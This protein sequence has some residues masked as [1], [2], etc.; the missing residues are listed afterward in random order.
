MYSRKKTV[1]LV[2]AI[3]ES[4]KNGIGGVRYACRSLLDS[5]LS[6]EM[7]WI[8]L[9]STV[10]IGSSLS[11][12]ALL[13]F[14]R[15]LRILHSLVVYPDIDSVLIFGNYDFT[16]F[17]EKGFLIILSK[18]FEKRT[19]LS[20]R[21]EIRKCKYDWL[22]TPFRNWVFRNCDQV[23]C[24]SS[25]AAKSLT[26]L[27]SCTTTK[28]TVIMNWINAISYLPPKK[29]VT[30]D[31]ATI[32]EFTFIF[33]GHLTM[34]KAPDVL[35]SAARILKERGLS[36][37]VVICGHGPLFDEL[38]QDIVKYQLSTAVQLCG[39]VIGEALLDMLWNADVF[40]LPSHSEGMPNA[41]LEAMAAGLPVIT[42]P[43]SSIPEIVTEFENGLFVQPGDIV[44]LTNAMEKM[45][46][47][48]QLREDM[49]KNN[50][51]RV[52]RNHTVDSAWPIIAKLL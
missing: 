32:S 12:R 11:K 47:S 26:N 31:E 48:S 45:I 49:S 40:V 5:P 34:N 30:A 3:A 19:L 44:S 38:A 28:I 13:A 27:T 25:V 1:I 9:D 46:V 33:V 4:T 23:L 15:V 41:L 7:N 22:F 18:A 29:A 20:L 8:T 10:P 17:L 24:Q 42:T 36:F 14:T 21:T 39:W 51:A 37:K 43:V 50:I 16:S 52:L 6:H 2:G 35:L